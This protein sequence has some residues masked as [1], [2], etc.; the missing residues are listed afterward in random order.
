MGTLTLALALHGWMAHVPHAD[1]WSDGIANAILLPPVQAFVT[2]V[3]LDA[4]GF[5]RPRDT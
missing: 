2:I 1:L 5:V 4:I 3:Y